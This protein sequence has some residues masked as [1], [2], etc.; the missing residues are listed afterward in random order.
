MLCIFSCVYWLFLYLLWRNV[1]LCPLYIFNWIICLLLLSCRNSLNIL[2]Y[3]Y[4]LDNYQNITCNSYFF[5]CMDFLFTFLIVLWNT[6]VQNFNSVQ[7]ICS[8]FC[9]LCHLLIFINFFVSLH[10][11]KIKRWVKILCLPY[12][13]FFHEEKRRVNRCIEESH[14]WIDSSSTS[15]RGQ[16]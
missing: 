9:Y 5:Y 2:N 14:F 11:S 10:W 16:P 6:K 3:R 7:F 15:F 8:F 1:Q 4:V 13:W 12:V